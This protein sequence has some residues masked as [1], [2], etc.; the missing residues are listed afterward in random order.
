MTESAMT[1]QP[2]RPTGD[3]MAGLNT[4]QRQAV[5][6]AGG[7]VL[8]I[9]GP[10]SGKTRVLT[11]RVAVLVRTHGVPAYRIMAVTFTNK[12]A[13]E[14]RERL[15]LLIGEQV[16]QLAVGTF[17]ANC[18]R[19]LR[20]DG[21]V[22]G[23]PSNFNIYD[24]DDQERLVRQAIKELNLDDKRYTPRAVLAAISQ[25]KSELKTPE[26][27]HAKT[28]WHEVAGR[29]YTRYDELLTA[30]DALD[31]DDL[32]MKT[33]LLL[34]QH[35]DVQEKYQQ[36]YL[37][38]LVDEFQDTNAAQYELLQLL[39][40][41][42]RNL[43]V[44]GDED[45]SIYSWRGADARHVQRFRHDYPDA[46]VVLLEQNYRSTQN[47][48]DVANAVISRN[49]GRTR[50]ELHTDR[51][52]GPKI[53]LRE[54]YNESQEA[55]FIAE[56][57]ERLVQ[58]RLCQLGDVAVM[59]R[60]NAQSRVVEDAFVVHGLPYKLVGATRFYERREIKDV[61]AYLRVLHNPRD[62]VSL[63]RIINVPARTIGASTIAGLNELA[64]RQ[65]C[66]LYEAIHVLEQNVDAASITARGRKSLLSFAHFMDDLIAMATQVNPVELLDTLLDRSGY[67]QYVRDGTEEGIERWENILEL[68]NVAAEY[69]YLPVESALSVLLEEVSL[70]SDVDNLTESNDLPTLLT[71]H[72]AK[73]LEFGTVFIVG[74][75]EGLL[76]HSRSLEDMD[77]LEEERRLC[78]VGITRAKDRLFLLHTFRRTQ[79]G[80]T[81][82]SEPSRFLSDIPRLLIEGQEAD[83]QK[84][85]AR[86]IDLGMGTGRYVKRSTPVAAP[87][88]P[89]PGEQ[90]VSLEPQFKIGDRVKHD[91]FGDGTVVESRMSRGD[92][93]VTVAFK[94]RGIKKLMAGYL[95]RAAD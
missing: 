14:M 19:I 55:T 40:G 43:F 75:N 12:A 79:Y 93:E 13:R 44:V 37:H 5:E 54:A 17:H 11:H 21:Q 63:A 49:R 18:V 59:Y 46:Q 92:E 34:K 80:T 42:Y 25:A 27:Y 57:I 50:K 6:S 32:L 28:Y 26:Q 48:L 82:F 58:S 10:G 91:S 7:P 90:R 88:I 56:E 71:L 64:T 70:V 83:D 62:A 73:G 9:A 84:Q 60:T 53:V 94:G 87:P 69:A 38:I 4:S 20:R 72:A 51:Q 65:D 78:Y 29:I 76:P 15:K 95:R 74:M 22:L 86:Q 31:F 2:E 77:A 67:A 85:T 16:N 39:S 3:L 45:Q 47:I 52:G 66:S 61:L 24:R 35:L 8:V 68:R 89:A 30:N 36:R 23:L 41:G 1:P 33:A 81:E